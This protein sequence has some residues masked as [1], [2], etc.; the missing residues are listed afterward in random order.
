MTE[1]PVELESVGGDPGDTVKIHSAGYFLEEGER[2]SV[3]SSPYDSR[4]PEPRPDVNRGEDPDRVFFVADDRPNPV[5][6]K[7]RDG[8][9]CYFRSLNRRHEWAAFSS[10]RAT[11]FQAIC[12]TR[13]IE[14]VQALDAECGNFVEDCATMLE[15]M[16]RRSGVRAKCLPASPAPVTTALPLGGVVEAVAN[17][18][19]GRRH[20]STEGTPI[21]QLKLFIDRRPCRCWN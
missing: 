2:V 7:L 6:L 4:R 15:S 3:A 19:S 5:S 8:E 9:S 11:V 13:A 14:L 21:G 10:H 16:V 1:A 17:D 18:I 12:F 20:L